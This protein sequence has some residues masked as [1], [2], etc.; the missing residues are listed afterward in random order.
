MRSVPV[1]SVI[2]SP[3]EYNAAQR[4]IKLYTKIRFRINFSGSQVMS[5]KPAD[6]VI[7]GAILNF[8]AAKYWTT[9]SASGTALKKTGSAASSVLASGTWVRF[10]APVEGMY[11]ITKSM[12]TS[13]G[14]DPTTVDP[15]TIKI[16]NNGGK[17]LPEDI[18][19]SRPSDL[20]ENAIIVAGQD[21]GKFD[22]G[23][24]ISVLWQRE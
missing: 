16:Y 23:D 15:R 2:I 17:V 9:K 10:E 22:D 21:D 20:V 14:I 8:N 11:K 19:A 12:L 4:T 1:Q 18:T 6:D 7:K 13:Y 3:I 5:S 24:Y